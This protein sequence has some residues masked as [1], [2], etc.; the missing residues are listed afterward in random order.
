MRIKELKEELYKVFPLHLQESY[1]NC[2]LLI[3]DEENEVNNILVT[4]DVTEEVIDEAIE[5]ECNV[6]VAHHPIIFRGLK[7]FTGQN[8]VER[9]VI[10]AIKHDLAIFA[11]HT[12]VD[13]SSRG[14]SFELAKVL[15]LNNLKPLDTDGDKVIGCIG[16]YSGQEDFIQYI[17]TLLGIKLIKCSGA[18]NRKS[19]G[20]VNV[21]IVTGSGSEFYETAKSKE[22]DALLS[23]DFKYH[24][25]FDSEDG[26]MIIDIGH[27]ESEI[28]V[29][30]I[31]FREI[32]LILSKYSISLQ[33]IYTS[34]VN[35]NPVNVE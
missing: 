22:C 27:Y 16:E 19:N 35:T 14:T 24:Q 12:N 17:K 13:N 15:R 9:C 34:G 28:F 8:Y 11:M 32:S 1:D 7:R 6:I 23:A 4:L 18:I 10:K 20:V 21:G 30:D 33:K 2:G 25:Y 29:K 5:K 3:G 31:F 26:P